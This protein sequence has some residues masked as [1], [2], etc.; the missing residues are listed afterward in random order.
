LATLETEVAYS[1]IT[2]FF[3]C[4]DDSLNGLPDVVFIVGALLYF[5]PEFKVSDHQ[6]Y[7]EDG[8]CIGMHYSRVTARG[9]RENPV[10]VS[11]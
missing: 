5:F 7:F 4:L 11:V 8:Y 9:K 10:V 6:K 3:N 2:S 1:P